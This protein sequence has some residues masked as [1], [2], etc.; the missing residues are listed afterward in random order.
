MSEETF[1]KR[2]RPRPAWATAVRWLCAKFGLELVDGMDSPAWRHSFLKESARHAAMDAAFR[3]SLERLR[4]AGKVKR[5][6]ALVTPMAPAETGIAN[7]SLQTFRGC[8]VGVDVF[9]RFEDAFAYAHFTSEAVSADLGLDVFDIGS[10]GLALQL[11]GYDAIVIAIGNSKHNR[12]VAAQFELLAKFGSSTP[13]FVHVHDP[14]LHDIWAW[15]AA[16]CDRSAATELATVYGGPMRTNFHRSIAFEMGALGLSAIIAD[17]AV[18]GIIVNSSSAERLVTKDLELAK[19]SIPVIRGFHPVFPPLVTPRPDSPPSAPVLVGSFGVPG[20]AKRTHVVYAAVQ[21]LRRRGIAAELML[22]GYGVSDYL[23]RHRRFD[24]SIIRVVDSP[25]D[26]TLQRLMVDV[27]VA[28]QLRREGLGESSGVVPQ[29]LALE[30]PVVVSDVGSF[31]EFGDA[32]LQIDKR[33][34]SEAVADSILSAHERRQQ[35]RENARAYCSQR[36]PAQFVQLIEQAIG[37]QS[38]DQFVSL[39]PHASRKAV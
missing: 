27:D 4:M 7:A 3:D 28:V 30:R 33:A 34:S 35:M 31:V 37:L 24:R 17:A 9:S 12:F 20:K 8:K 11:R 21:A 26:L 2:R 32:V 18:A 15:T 10:L 22:A 36:T 25:N 29:L 14:W 23:N 19:R 16:S 38:A 39:P 13:I 5:R 1:D 6:L